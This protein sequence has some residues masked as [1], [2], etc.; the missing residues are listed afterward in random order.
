MKRAEVLVQ[1]HRPSIGGGPGGM[2]PFFWNFVISALPITT[3][4]M[5]ERTANS[6]LPFCY[7]TR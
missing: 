3:G 5:I 1:R 4:I 6:L 2:G 7:R